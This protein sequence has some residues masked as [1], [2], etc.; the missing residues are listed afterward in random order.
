MLCKCQCDQIY[1]LWTS[2]YNYEKYPL[3]PLKLRFLALIEQYLPNVSDLLYSVHRSVV[4][5]L[6]LNWC[7]STFYPVT[8]PNDSKCWPVVTSLIQGWA[9]S[10]CEVTMT[11]YS[12][13]VS[14]ILSTMMLRTVIYRVCKRHVCAKF[15]RVCGAVKCLASDIMINW[16][17]AKRTA[18]NN[19]GQCARHEIMALIIMQRRGT[20]KNVNAMIKLVK[21]NARHE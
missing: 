19:G 21:G 6:W 17:R 20:M 14:V 11:D 2:Y 9:V 13:V 10:N 8:A 16:P 12:R 5:F 15:F 7:K 1:K 3:S 18:R 4:W